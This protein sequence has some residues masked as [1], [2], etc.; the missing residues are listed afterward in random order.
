MNAM[1]KKRA[2]FI[3]RD[4]TIVV[5]PPE[6]KQLDSLR[7]FSFVPGVIGALKKLVECKLY[8]LVLVSNQDGLGTGS[9]PEDTFWPPHNLM[10]NTLKGEG[11]EFSEVFID[12]SLPGEGKPTRKPGTAM[13]TGYMGGEYD[14]ARSWV[15][16][17]RDTDIQLAKNLGAK[18]IFY[19]SQESQGCEGHPAQNWNEIAERILNETR[20]STMN[21]ITKETSV[22]IS[23]DLDGSGKSKIDTG[24]P[25]FN[26]MLDLFAYHAKVDLEITANGDLPHHLIED[27]GIVLGTCLSRAVRAKVGMKRYGFFLL[28]MDEALAQVSLDFSGRSSFQWKVPF[29]YEQLEGMPTEMFS[30]FFGS[31]VENAKMT[32][33]VVVS[34]ENEHHKIEAVFKGF[35]RSVREAVSIDEAFSKFIPS[36]KGTL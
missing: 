33:S 9:F 21:R 36:T 30:H 10:M 19:G 35:G 27:V 34:G 2:L 29:T 12:R 24:I 8:E 32:L 13:L 25:F 28:P 16:G 26:H 18:G 11:I 23:L 3:D 15:I 20:A 31:V 17:D 22:A 1:F 5:E 14:L 7:K 6:D 4:G